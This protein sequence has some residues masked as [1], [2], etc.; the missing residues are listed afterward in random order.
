MKVRLI[1]I[2]EER[3]FEVFIEIKLDF[4]LGIEYMEGVVFL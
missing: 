2:V 3:D 1:D 4:R